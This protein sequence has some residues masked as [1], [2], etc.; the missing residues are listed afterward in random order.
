MLGGK[1]QDFSVVHRRAL[2]HV[3]RGGVEPRYCDMVPKN[4]NACRM[5]HLRFKLVLLRITERQSYL[6]GQLLP[7]IKLQVR[8]KF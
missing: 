5:E 6:S 8:K 7:I 4:F 3:S 1:F 2:T